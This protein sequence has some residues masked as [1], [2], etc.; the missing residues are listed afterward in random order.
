MRTQKIYFPDRHTPCVF[1]MLRS[2]LPEATSELKLDGSYPV[3]VLIGGEIDEHQAHASQQAIQTIAK[4]AERLHAVIICGGTNMG[5]MAKIG[6]IRLLNHYKFPLIGVAPE[7]LVAWPGGPHNTKFLWWGKQRWQLESHYSHFILVP[8]SQF[9]DE[10][11]WIVDAATILSKGHSSVTI[12]I[13][14]GEV[15]R[16]DIDLSLEDGRLVIALNH[17]GRLADEYSRDVNKS[18]LIKIV[19]ATDEQRM[20]DIIQM[21]LSVDE[22][23]LL[24]QA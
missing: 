23:K 16:K 18:K 3:I 4:V 10:S 22:R 7:E 1:P 8:G 24:S 15:S 20:I 5:V 9:G 17:T 2:D 14:G 13:N 6:Q 12:L 11:P 19:S 21:A